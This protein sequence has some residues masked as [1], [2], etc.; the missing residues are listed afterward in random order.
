[1]VSGEKMRSQD[2][3]QN[4]NFK[5]W[6]NKFILKECDVIETNVKKN[7]QKL[8]WLKSYEALIFEFPAILLLFLET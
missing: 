1:M 2:W 7:V 6:Q 8:N 5:I 4:S 3:K